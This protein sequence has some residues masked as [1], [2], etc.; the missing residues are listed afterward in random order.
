MSDRTTRILIVLAVGATGGIVLYVS[1]FL[2]AGSSPDSIQQMLLLRE[3]ASTAVLG[4]AIGTGYVLYGGEEL[5]RSAVGVIGLFL[6]SGLS[7]YALGYVALALAPPEGFTL[8]SHL[9]TFTLLALREVVPFTIAGFSGA[10]FRTLR[11]AGRG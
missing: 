4:A 10:A 8:G 9:S 5:R 7:G 3:V 1:Q 11:G 6:L 2:E